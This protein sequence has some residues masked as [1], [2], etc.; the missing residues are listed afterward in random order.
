M[1]FGKRVP[2]IIE[3]RCRLDLPLRN[4][5][6]DVEGSW[7]NVVK[8]I[9]ADAAETR[10]VRYETYTDGEGVYQVWRADA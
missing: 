8:E 6:F 10:C 4:R 2:D 9:T 3:L 1:I 7:N 5:D